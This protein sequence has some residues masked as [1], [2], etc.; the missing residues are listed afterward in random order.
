MFHI[1]S[2]RISVIIASILLPTIIFSFEVFTGENGVRITIGADETENFSVENL[3]IG[4]RNFSFVRY[5]NAQYTT[6]SGAP[7]LPVFT[8]VVGLPASGSVDF[9]YDVGW[10]DVQKLDF[11]IVPADSSCWENGE[12][13]QIYAEP[14]ERIYRSKSVFPQKT[15]WFDTIGFFRSQKIGRIFVSPIEYQPSSGTFRFA[16]KITIDVKFTP[17]GSY[18]D[19]GDFE[20]VFKNLLVNYEQ[21]KN[22]RR[23]NIIISVPDNPFSPADIWYRSA[24]RSGGIF[25]ITSDWL[26]EA[27]LN[28]D[29]ISP[30]DIRV[31][32]Y[33]IGILPTSLSDNFPTPEEIPLVSIDNGDEIFNDG[34]TLL[35]YIPAPEWWTAEGGNV[36]WHQSPYCDSTSVWIAVGGD[37]SEPAKRL[38]QISVIGAADERNF[39]WTLSHIGEDLLFEEEEKRWYWQR[40]ES[41][42]ALFLTDPRVNTDRFPNGFIRCE[43]TGSC[44]GIDCNGTSYSYPIASS[45]GVN[46]LVAGSNMITFH[47]NDTVLFRYMEVRYLITLT[48]QDGELH[49]FTDTLSPQPSLDNPAKFMLSD[50]DDPMVFDVSHYPDIRWLATEGEGNNFYFAD[51][52]PQREYF[53]FDKNTIKTLPAPQVLNDFSLW[54]EPQS[55]TDYVMVAPKELDPSRLAEFWSENGLNVKIYEIEDIMAQFGFGR[56][57]P[58]AIRNFLYYLYIRSDDP[59][60]QY[61]AF[62]GDGHYD[63]RHRI[64]DSKEYFPPAM[65]AS[66]FTDAFFS[67]FS[68]GEI[69]LEMMAGR[70]PA[71]NQSELDDIIKKTIDYNTC[72][73]EG[74]WRLNSILT[75]DDEYRDD[76]RNDNLSYTSNNSDIAANY[77]PP[78]GFFDPVYLV[79]YPR[80]STLRKP[81]A[82]DALMN[83]LLSGAVWL[84]WIGHG[85]YHLWAHEHLIDFPGDM[86]RWQCGKKIPLVSSFSCY[87]GE[88]FR[89]G[90]KECIAEILLRAKDNGAIAVISATSGSSPTSNHNMNRR[91]AQNIFADEPMPVGGAMIAARNGL[92][93]SH[94]SQYILMGDPATTLAYP[95]GNIA[96][97]MEPDTIIPGIWLQISGTADE[98]VDGEAMIF[99]QGP[100]ITKHYDSPIIDAS[101]DYIHPGKVLFAGAAS[102]HDG[103]FSLPVFVPKI[104]QDTTGYRVII[105]IYGAEDCYNASSATTDIPAN[106]SAASDIVDTTGP[107][108]DITFDSDDFSDGGTVCSQDGSLPITITLSDS[109]GIDMGTTP[110]HEVILQLDDDFNR[111]DVSQNLTYVVDDPTQAIVNYTYTNVAYGGHTV[112]VQAWDNL[113]NF[114]QKCVDLMLEQ[115]T[116]DIYDV[117]PYPNPFHNGVDITFALA[118]TNA[119]AEITLS[120]FSIGGREIF[121]TSKRTDKPFDWIHWDGN[122]PD[123]SAVAR[124]VY[125]YVLKA[126]IHSPDG[127]TETKIIRGKIVKE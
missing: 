38:A 58:T 40:A 68:D 117:L 51:T 90:G 7:L 13:K 19:E 98:S 126:K 106:P 85:N 28:P 26:E 10:S 116:C 91:L 112:C 84:N 54:N 99:L 23:Q 73:P 75:A 120:I 118:G 46:S 102:V 43:A 39:G 104:L 89:T 71:R 41:Q 123:G 6:T 66:H 61:V 34:D 93:P 20:K 76:G 45:D 97:N 56:Y 72:A 92:Y 32:T 55:Q 29:E 108:I 96:I 109:H 5:Y 2:P 105:Y 82:T 107:E 77:L 17:N 125:I 30:S 33:G 1:F 62:V 79:D 115:C 11:P 114:S 67:T 127:K 87:V 4:R 42:I 12:L 80:T 48:P 103:E 69:S 88:F 24:V 110:G 49:F 44:S 52:S 113:G 14:D 60:P 31:F 101:V 78:Q 50:F 22:M 74:K 83:Y 8:Y 36:E 16:R 25:A 81:E 100:P 57:D 119:E 37:F 35:F 59:K 86:T 21:A 18:I 121:S 65:L 15:V 53:V 94:D 111:V 64:T 124:G 95:Y 3:S 47:F 63:Y 9:E 27:G 70:L 122:S